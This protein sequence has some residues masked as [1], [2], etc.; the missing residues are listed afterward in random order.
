MFWPTD[1]PW[2]TGGLWGN[3]FASA[4]CFALS[5]TY[6]EVKNQARHKEIVKQQTK[7]HTRLRALENKQ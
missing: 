5:T 6:L 7:I 2:Y 1:A 3:L 4:I